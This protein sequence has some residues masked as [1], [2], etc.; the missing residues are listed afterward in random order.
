M[1]IAC[2]GFIPA[3]FP[4]PASD[5]SEDSIDINR[6]IIEHPTATFFFR[7]EGESMT[8]AH[9]PPNALL[10]VDR[11]LKPK[12]GSIVVAVVD[13]EFTVKRL[14]KKVGSLRLLPENPRFKPLE[15]TEG[16]TFEVWGVVRAIV[17]DKPE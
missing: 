13:G 8:G 10:V 5:Y 7:A 4:S 9:I 17:I 3:G 12:N 6:H 11:A 2:Y 15:I 16:M 1:L 14:E